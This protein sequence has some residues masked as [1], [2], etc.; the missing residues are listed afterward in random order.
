MCE[1]KCIR[2]QQLLGP[3]LSH[4]RRVL[5][6]PIFSFYGYIENFHL[7]FIIGSKIRC[8][9]FG[10]YSV[11]SSFAFAKIWVWVESDNGQPVNMQPCNER[12]FSP[13][14][15]IFFFSVFLFRVYNV[16]ICGVFVACARQVANHFCQV[17]VCAIFCRL[18]PLHVRE[19]ATHS[20]SNSSSSTREHRWFIH[21]VLFGE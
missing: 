4:S 1:A 16:C 9:V 12:L 3:P 17:G 10:R 15:F 21:F 14:F 7:A 11:Y 19:I 5:W 6:C 8:S 13:S 2:R 18:T 20:S